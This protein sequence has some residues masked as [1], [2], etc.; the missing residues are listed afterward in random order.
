MTD[1]SN[2]YFLVRKLHALSGLILLG[3]AFLITLWSQA[4][5]V[6]GRAAYNQAMGGT[7]EL[8]YGFLFEILV[9]GV[10]FLFYAGYGAVLWWRS[11]HILM[12]NV[13]RYSEFYN[14]LY[15]LQRISGGI[16][17]LFILTYLY[18][19]RV[20]VLM[21]PELSQDMYGHMQSLLS[22]P[23]MFAWFMIGLLAVCFHFANGLRAM[24]IN[25]GFTINQRSQ[26]MATLT[27]ALL[28]VGLFLYGMRS[29]VGFDVMV[30]LFG[31]SPS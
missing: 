7:G 24:C 18:T 4:N 1:T 19:T 16:G 3:G 26:N 12:G 2:K 29:L 14:W 5:A 9:I 15:L 30:K 17:F 22:H 23:L 31:I 21:Q 10:P 28:F 20:Q 27:T 13:G 6:Y 11:Q 25:W 8:G